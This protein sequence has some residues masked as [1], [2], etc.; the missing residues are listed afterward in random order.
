MEKY[1]LAK[2]QLKV[3]FLGGIGEIGKN[4]TALEYGGEILVIDGG[5]AFPTMDM[6]GIDLVIPD[7]SYLTENKDKIKRF[8]FTPSYCLKPKFS[9]C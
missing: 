1:N 5:L 7:Y 8:G 9:S 6:P 3:I 4:M 2:E